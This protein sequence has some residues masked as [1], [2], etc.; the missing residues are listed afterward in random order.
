MV[1]IPT[2]MDA[3]ALLDK[4]FGRARKVKGAKKTKAINK[5]STVKQVMNDTLQ[6]YV[7]AFP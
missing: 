2:I 4:A 3:D 7:K 6:K 1:R 5:I